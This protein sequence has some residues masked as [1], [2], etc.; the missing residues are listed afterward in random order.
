MAGYASLTLILEVARAD[1]YVAVINGLMSNVLMLELGSK[2][3]KGQVTGNIRIK[4]C[5]LLEKQS[6]KAKVATSSHT[7]LNIYKVLKLEVFFHLEDQT[8]KM[9]I[10]STQLHS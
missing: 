3:G 9:N 4:E 10:Q 8:Q 5:I 2:H 1:A 7:A 6:S